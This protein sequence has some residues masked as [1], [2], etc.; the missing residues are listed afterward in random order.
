MWVYLC[1]AGRVYAMDFYPRSERLDD[2]KRAEKGPDWS[3]SPL[4]DG[5]MLEIENNT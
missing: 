5:A 1:R 2:F 3:Q 4:G